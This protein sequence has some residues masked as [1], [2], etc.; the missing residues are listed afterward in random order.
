MLAKPHHELRFTCGV[1]KKSYNLHQL[2][3]LEYP[4]VCE[5][6]VNGQ[7]VGIPVRSFYFQWLW[8]GLQH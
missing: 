5:L 2:V 8:K 4:P 1:L 7:R 6:S 3:P